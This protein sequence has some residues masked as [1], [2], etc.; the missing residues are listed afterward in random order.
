MFGTRYYDPSVGRW[1]Q[2]DALAGSIDD[3][4][5]VNRYVYAGCDPV[6]FVDSEGLRR[7]RKGFSN[8]ES[9]AIAGAIGGNIGTG[10]GA[11]AGSFTGPAGTVAGALGGY[12]TGY[13]TSCVGA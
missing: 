13:A 2:Q 9:C 8:A 3:P 12:V 10:L 4:S 5:T 11:T 7:N 6:N 1:T